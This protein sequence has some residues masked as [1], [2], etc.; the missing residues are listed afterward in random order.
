MMPL[1][2]VYF[3]PGSQSQR[4]LWM[5]PLCH[6]SLV[7]APGLYPL[8][9]VALCV[10]LSRCYVSRFHPEHQ[11]HKGPGVPNAAQ[12][13]PTRICRTKHLVK[14]LRFSDYDVIE[15]NKIILKVIQEMR[16]FRS[17]PHWTVYNCH[18]KVL[19]NIGNETYVLLKTLET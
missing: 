18:T 6:P 9:S 1:F 13:I 11:V 14:D 2:H 17:V 10:S 15:F 4:G 16:W 8:S 5:E 3:W 12:I 7:V 19:K